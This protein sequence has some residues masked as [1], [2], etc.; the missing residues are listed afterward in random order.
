MTWLIMDY[1]GKKKL[2][3]T[4]NE[5]INMNTEFNGSKILAKEFEGE[6]WIKAS[7]INLAANAEVERLTR[8]LAEKQQQIN[9]FYSGNPNGGIVAQL[10]KQLAAAQMDAE[11]YHA[12]RQAMVNDDEGFCDLVIAHQPERPGKTTNEIVDAAIDAAMQ[13]KEGE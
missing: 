2:E 10:Q 8:E 7:D 9:A 6:L 4:K 3:Q 1:L 12:I 11:R 13:G 5:E